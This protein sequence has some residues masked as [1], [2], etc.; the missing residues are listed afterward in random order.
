[1][2][3]LLPYLVRLLLVRLILPAPG[4]MSVRRCAQEVGTV[5]LMTAA[6]ALRDTLAAELG[7]SRWATPMAALAVRFSGRG[8]EHLGRAVAGV[9]DRLLAVAPN[10][11]RWNG[12]LPGGGDRRR[13]GKPR[14][15]AR[16]APLLEAL[17]SLDVLPPHATMIY[18]DDGEGESVLPR[19]FG[20]WLGLVDPSVHAFCAPGGFLMVGWPM[21]QLERG[22][23]LVADSEIIVRELAAE[24]A[25]LGPAI[26][27]APSPLFNA[28]SNRLAVGKEFHARHPQVGA[29][30]VEAHASPFHHAAR[31]QGVDLFDGV[32][33][34]AW[35]TWLSSKLARRV[36]GY[37]GVRAT[38][39]GLTR[40]SLSET[41]PFAMDEP[42]YA[43]WRAGWEAM[44]SARISLRPP[45][46]TPTEQASSEHDDWHGYLGRFNAPTFAAS[47]E[48]VEDVLKRSIV[49]KERQIEAEQALE[50]AVRRSPE[51]V[52]VAAQ[53]LA[54]EVSFEK[55]LWK[56]ADAFP[57]LLKAGHVSVAD[58]E[59]WLRRGLDAGLPGARTQLAERM[60]NAA[61]AAKLDVL[62]FEALLTARPRSPGARAEWVER[63]ERITPVRRLRNDPRWRSLR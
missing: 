4:V 8:L 7:E 36:R 62:A 57:A 21:T 59:A 29:P 1:M 30:S 44:G 52:L 33:T 49:A 58:V 41:V 26:W 15:L 5:A 60:A 28:A 40:F 10:D 39:D 23:A 14:P 25:W 27:L 38:Q 16:R 18:A 50:D 53:R 24:V 12:Y 22:D 20:L 37:P 35:T 31:E 48:D 2:R 19:S 54:D 51:Q 45:T 55:A 61:V 32:L 56:L 3:L 11:T 13:V 46:F 6:T 9:V 42:T 47:L 63:L 17:A 43:A 34:P